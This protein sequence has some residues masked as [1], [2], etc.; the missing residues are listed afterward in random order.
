MIVEEFRDKGRRLLEKQIK[1]TVSWD[2]GKRLRATLRL[3]PDTSLEQRQ[4]KLV[5][6]R[7]QKV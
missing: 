7:E 3:N 5:S 1:C 4:I 6:L 2:D